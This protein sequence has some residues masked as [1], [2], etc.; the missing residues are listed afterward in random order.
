MWIFTKEGF[1]SVVQDDYC[2]ADELMVRAR[3]RKDLVRL[4]DRL[5]LKK[6]ILAINHADYQYRMKVRRL[7]WADYCCQAALGVDYSNVK[8][9]IAQGDKK[10]SRAYMDAWGALVSASIRG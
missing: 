9:T 3:W 4:A 1:F 7:V 8:G 5:G 10:R 6:K 2:A